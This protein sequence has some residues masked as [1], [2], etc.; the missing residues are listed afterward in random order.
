MKIGFAGVL[1]TGL[2]AACTVMGQLGPQAPTTPASVRSA[3]AAIA[4]EV[5]E[6]N[7]HSYI[8][9]MVSFGTRST[10]SDQT[11]NTRGIGAARRWVESEFRSIGSACGGCLEIVLPE[12]T[13]TGQ[14]YPQPTKVVDVVAIQRGTTEPNRVIIIQGHLDSRNSTNENVTDDAPGAND[15]AS[16]VAAVIEAARILSKRKFPATLVFAALSGEEQG[17]SGGKILADYARAQ[18]WQVEAV[19]NNDIVGASEGME[20]MTD[21]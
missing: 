8:E 14:R 2:A 13:V 9:K 1:L 21:T 17:L 18:G 4:A 12:D 7:Q 3:L 11:S 6:T 20:G 5:S 10:L 15:D 19:L 16:G